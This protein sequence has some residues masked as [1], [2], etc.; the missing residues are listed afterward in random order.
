M[1]AKPFGWGLFRRREVVVPTW[2]GQLLGAILL[3]A[4]LRSIQVT[5]QPFLSVHEPIGGDVLV[6]EGW[7]PDYALREAL[8]AF[9]SRPYRLLLT[10]GGPVP[11]G[12]AFSYH[13]NYARLAAATLAEFGLPPDSIAEIPSPDVLRDRTYAEGVALKEWMRTHGAP[14]SL[15]LFS[16]STHSRRSRLLYAKALG[17]G[18]R[19]GVYAPPD[20]QY[21][22]AH[23]WRSSN[24]VR[25]VSDEVI[26]YL[27]ARFLFR[28]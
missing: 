5:V 16:F 28:E 27:Y 9:R 7:I 6:V 17:R 25:R 26:A 4:L 22:P 3:L 19:I 12:M 8:V 13:K 10:T 11:Q 1:D 14:A 24:G 20:V 18:T 2:R 21:D 15:D 23:W